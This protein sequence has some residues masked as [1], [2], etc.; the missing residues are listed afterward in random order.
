MEGKRSY[1]ITEFCHRFVADYIEEGSC[2]ID[3]T[4]GNGGDT[5]FLCRMAGERGR[6]YA[7]DIQEEAV[8]KT[9]DRLEQAGYRERAVLYRTG[10]EKMAEYVHQEAA[11]IMF[12]F[13]YLPGG[14]HTV[15]TQAETSVEAVR[16]GLGLLKPGGVMSL[17]IYSG[18]DTGYDEKQALLGFL[19]DL[20]PAKWLVIS[21]RYYN[22]KNDPPEPVFVIRLT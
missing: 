6:V 18:G 13:G 17:C 2:C 4:C 8:R 3:A 9:G 12:N 15:A 10:H 14:D 22:R 21:C 19:K 1:Q 11:A 5:E 16:Q 7:F 20:D